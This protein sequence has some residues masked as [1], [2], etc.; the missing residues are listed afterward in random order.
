MTTPTPERCFKKAKTSGS[1]TQLDD[2]IYPCDQAAWLAE[3]TGSWRWDKGPN[4]V[5]DWSGMNFNKGEKEAWN[6]EESSDFVIAIIGVYSY[7][8]FGSI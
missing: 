1:A 2:K 7:A 3:T 5:A 4:F 6:D 8:C